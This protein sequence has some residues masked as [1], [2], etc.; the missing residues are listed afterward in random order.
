MKRADARDSSQ[1]L[2]PA[3]P[4]I[5]PGHWSDGQVTEDLAGHTRSLGFV[6]RERGSPRRVRAGE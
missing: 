1:G 2:A 6:L 3:I 5:S 4:S